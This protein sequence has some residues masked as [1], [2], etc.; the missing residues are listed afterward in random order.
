V[1]TTLKLKKRKLEIELS[2]TTG[3]L[4]W[5]KKH[6]E[7][8]KNRCVRLKSAF[9]NKKKYDVNV[10]DNISFDAALVLVCEQAEVENSQ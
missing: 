1:L 5:Q 7:L 8:L 10:E 9:M 6:C 2:D 4:E 3:M